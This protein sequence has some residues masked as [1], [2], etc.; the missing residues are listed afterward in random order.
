MVLAGSREGSSKKLGE[1]ASRMVIE[2]V[3]TTGEVDAMGVP[4]MRGDGY[5]AGGKGGLG[6]GMGGLCRELARN[7]H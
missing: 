3:S 6:T 1:I 5:V 2:W 7:L 4:C